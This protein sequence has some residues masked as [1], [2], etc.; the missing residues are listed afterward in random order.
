MDSEKVDLWGINVPQPVT[1]LGKTVATQLRR[2]DMQKPTILRLEW[3]PEKRLVLVEV[4][5]KPEMPNVA[6]IPQEQCS[7]I[8]PEE[9]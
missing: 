3:Y 5:K 1:I 8:I 2:G 7:A 4:E 9:S 6:F